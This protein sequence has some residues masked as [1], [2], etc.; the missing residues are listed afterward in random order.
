MSKEITSREVD[1]S[2]WYL[3]IVKKAGL[4]DN[5]PVRGC[6]IIKPYGFKL[7]ENMRDAMDA[8]FKETPFS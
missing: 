5:S 1:Y 7:W 3:D 6:M 8:M 4:A 2:Q